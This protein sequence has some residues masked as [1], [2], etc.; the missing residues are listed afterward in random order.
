MKTIAATTF[1]VLVALAFGTT[2]AEAQTKK[3]FPGAACVEVDA[4]GDPEIYY[5]S[6]DGSAH[7]TATGPYVTFR[8]PIMRETPDTSSITNA[9]ARVANNG[10]GVLT[11]FVRSC[12]KDGVTCSNSVPPA[13]A[14]GTCNPSQTCLLDLGSVIGYTEG[15]AHVECAV[16]PRSISG[17]GAGII[18]YRWED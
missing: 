14:L 8:C 5:S 13:P 4:D 2:S 11:C 17:P 7:T 1:L 6:S 9:F 18:Y 12:T 10:E 15:Y 3:S 16:P